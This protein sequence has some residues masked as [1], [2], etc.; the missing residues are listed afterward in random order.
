MKFS[1]FAKFHLARKGKW[2]LPL[3]SSSEKISKAKDIDNNKILKKIYVYPKYQSKFCQVSYKN[4][5][6]LDFILYLEKKGT[7]LLYKTR[8]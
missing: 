2:Y 1:D 8:I 3:P 4:Y 5:S 6:S 7:H